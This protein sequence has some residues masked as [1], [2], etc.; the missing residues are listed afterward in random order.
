M[1]GKEGEGEAGKGQE[2]N[3]MELERVGEKRGAFLS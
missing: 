2:G 3:G 1:K